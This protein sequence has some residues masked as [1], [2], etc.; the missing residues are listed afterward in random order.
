MFTAML[1]PWFAWAAFRGI[2]C[3]GSERRDDPRSEA[4]DSSSAGRNLEGE[5]GEK[6][7][8][9][10][11]IRIRVCW[12]Q[13]NGLGRMERR[14][15]FIKFLWINTTFTAP[16]PRSAGILGSSESTFTNFQLGDS[17]G[18]ITQGPSRFI[19]SGMCKFEGSFF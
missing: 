2:A 19:E 4:S 5:T 8:I 16:F 15:A 17:E 13:L 12:L 6:E 7:L 10:R 14:V 3:Q 9:C 18:R 1:F 11:G